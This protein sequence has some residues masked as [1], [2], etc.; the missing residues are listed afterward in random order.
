MMIGDWHDKTILA[1]SLGEFLEKE[2]DL[3]ESNR[4]GSMECYQALLASCETQVESIL[5]DV[6]Q[7]IA[8]STTDADG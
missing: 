3:P 1:E 2:V 7:A 5:L 4:V 6:R 8:A